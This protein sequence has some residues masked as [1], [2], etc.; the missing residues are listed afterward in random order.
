MALDVVV[1]DDRLVVVG[2]Q[3]MALD[4][5]G[6]MFQ[7]A[8]RQVRHRCPPRSVLPATAGPWHRTLPPAPALGGS[9]LARCHRSDTSPCI[10]ATRARFRRM[11]ATWG[12]SGP[13]DVT[14]MSSAR[15]YDA[16]ASAMC[17]RR[18]CMV[19]RLL[20]VTARLGDAGPDARSLMVMAR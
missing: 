13:A 19:A 8:T 3:A 11:T 14:R 18:R 1:V 20:S 9:R 17:P 12:W 2:G 15:V 16:A 5:I 4:V 6:V 7:G 10:A